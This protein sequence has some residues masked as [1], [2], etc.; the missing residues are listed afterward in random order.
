VHRKEACVI[1]RFLDA[2]FQ[3]KLMILLPPLLIPL[4]VGPIAL[5]LA[6]VYYETWA[7]IWVD[8]PTYLS[9]NDDWNRYLTPAQNQTGRLN[10]LLRT[11]SFVLEIA[12]R[13]QLAPLIG[14]ARG[15]DKIAD[16]LGKGL[17][18]VPNGNQLILFRFRA[19]SPQVS[20]DVAN[21][22]IDNFREK[23]ANDRASQA[24]LAISFYESRQQ[25]AQ[26]EYKQARDALRRYIA[27]NP[28]LTTIDPTRG[29]GATTAARLGLPAAAIDPQL[30]ELLHQ[31][32]V[33]E[34]DLN[35]ARKS[36]D[37]AR[38]DASASLEAQDLGFQIVDA[39]QMPTTATRE[40]R[41]MLIYPLA[42]LLVGLGLSGALLVLL[43]V[44][45]RTAHAE[46]DLPS[47]QVLGSVPHVKTTWIRKKTVGPE[48][49]RRAVG[50]VAG[51]ALPA[52]AGAR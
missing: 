2:F 49:A 36:L 29:A 7:G 32:D 13:T 24:A 30:A 1:T 46:E 42:A 27:A 37:Q 51:T 15:E 20:F 14:T 47:V 4:I 19:E 12:R 34:D 23:A 48:S 39:P 6:P 33:A 52:P 43:V 5:L 26:D 9:Y 40:R 44:G 22:V 50:Y 38:L 16:I 10:E 25:S 17:S 11:R 18:I 28:R 31:L 41:K 3:H 21:A 45:D 35:S 8:R